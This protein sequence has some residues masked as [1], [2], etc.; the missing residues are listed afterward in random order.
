MLKQ[1]AQPQ[2]ILPRNASQ[3]LDKSKLVS[4]KIQLEPLN[5]QVPVPKTTESPTKQTPSQKKQHYQS[6]S[7]NSS[8]N[9][10]RNSAFDLYK[11][12]NPYRMGGQIESLGAIE[13]VKQ[14]LIY[15]W[16]NIYRILIQIDATGSGLV[17]QSEFLN[18]VQKARVYVTREELRKLTERFR[19]P[20]NPDK[21]QYE[22]LSEK[23][24]LHRSSLNFIKSNKQ[25][26]L[27]LAA[28]KMKSLMHTT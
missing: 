11:T 5:Q 3:I 19:D 6:Q 15:E 23:L 18:A 24:G 28:L 2:K 25:K 9:F 12:G 20:A 4:G 27:Q 26:N 17:S 21:V 13:M 22:E 7:P 1:N 10:G 8:V 16:K 14:R